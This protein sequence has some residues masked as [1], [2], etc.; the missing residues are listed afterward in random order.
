MLLA[1]G[2]PGPMELA[3]I[4]GLLLLFFGAGKLPQAGQ[5]LGLGIRNFKKAMNGGEND[6]VDV[7]PKGGDKALE[8]GKSEAEGAESK[9]TENAKS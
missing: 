1:I 3:L 2:M 5:A 7:T 4:G 6:E 8:P 9:S